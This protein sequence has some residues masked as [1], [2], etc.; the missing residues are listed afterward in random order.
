[1]I[2]SNSTGPRDGSSDNELQ[3]TEP[4]VYVVSGKMI[5]PVLTLC[6]A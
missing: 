1:M 4:R 6:M 5:K 3:R 2:A